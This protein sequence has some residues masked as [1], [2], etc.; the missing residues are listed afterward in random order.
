MYFGVLWCAYNLDFEAENALSRG[1]ISPGSHK[2]VGEMPHLR[3]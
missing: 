1:F 3:T 2:N